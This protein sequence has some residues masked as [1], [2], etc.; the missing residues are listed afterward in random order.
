MGQVFVL[1][2]EKIKSFFFVLSEIL[3]DD[4]N[5]NFDVVEDGGHQD[6][7]EG[8]AEDDIDIYEDLDA[9]AKDS[10]ANSNIIKKF[11]RLF[12]PQKKKCVI[13]EGLPLENE[14]DEEDVGLYDDLNTFESQ[15]AAE[16]VR[17][18]GIHILSNSAFTV[19]PCFNI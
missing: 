11:N 15:L 14:T 5:E 3:M 1:L 2:E 19:K 4:I 10:D 13:E 16:E 7:E 6:E 18:M 9:A 8:E 17:E 12:S